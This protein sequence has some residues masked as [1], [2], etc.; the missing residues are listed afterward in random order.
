MFKFNNEIYIYKTTLLSF[1]LQ[2]DNWNLRTFK[3][4]IS[5]AIIIKLITG[6][7]VIINLR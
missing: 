6:R 3:M 7:Y 4:N 1:A 5:K 2:S